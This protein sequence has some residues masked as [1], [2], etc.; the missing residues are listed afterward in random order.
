[1]Q[2]YQFLL[3]FEFPPFQPFYKRAGR[4]RTKS[5]VLG[6]EALSWGRNLFSA[7]SGTLKRAAV[8]LLVVLTCVAIDKATASREDDSLMTEEALL[9]TGEVSPDGTVT[10]TDAASGPSGGVGPEQV[11]SGT[12]ASRLSQFAD[13]ALARAKAAGVS[14]LSGAKDAAVRTVEKTKTFGAEAAAAAVNA[15]G[16]L[17]EASKDVKESALL[18]AKAAGAAAANAVERAGII[19]ANAAKA[20]KQGAEEAGAATVKAA[21]KLGGI[22]GSAADNAIEHAKAA[23]G[24]AA[25]GAISAAQ[26]VTEETA[27]LARRALFSAAN[28]TIGAADSVATAAKSVWSGLLDTAGG[29]ASALLRRPSAALLR[30]AAVPVATAAYRFVDTW[31]LLLAWAAVAEA[32]WALITPLFAACVA[33]MCSCRR[34]GTIPAAGGSGADS[35]RLSARC[36]RG[37][38][39]LEGAPLTVLLVGAAAMVSIALLVMPKASASHG[40]KADAGDSPSGTHA[41]ERMKGQIASCIALA[42]LLAALIISISEWARPELLL[43][44]SWRLLSAALLFGARLVWQSAGAAACE[45]G[46]RAMG[47]AAIVALESGLLATLAAP[48]VGGSLVAAAASAIRLAGG[49]IGVG[50]ATAVETAFAAAGAASEAVSAG[51]LLALAAR[52]AALNRLLRPVLGPG[53]IGVVAAVLHMLV[54]HRSA[55]TRHLAVLSWPLGSGRPHVA[56]LSNAA[57]PAAAATTDALINQLVLEVRQLRKV[58]DSRRDEAS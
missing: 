51:W 54:F 18:N 12:P 48:A 44:R 39:L 30:L 21:Q 19:G 11:S 23:G 28:A 40:S 22:A 14:A 9:Q 13:A 43:R 33:G 49:P 20:V 25:G 52:A 53:A 45:A 7:M 24:A 8:V 10:V 57:A 34:V 1:M 27:A 5:N 38:R 46:E 15:A 31:M 35:R 26:M 55:F 36:A 6:V 41:A 2:I 56:S 17:A 42:G 32:A 58:V 29:T 37:N 16:R 47:T 50:L 4:Q 3:M